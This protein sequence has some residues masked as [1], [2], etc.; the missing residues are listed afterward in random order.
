MLQLQPPELFLHL[1]NLSEVGFDVLILWIVYLV[2]EVDE[3][4][5]IALDD[6]ELHP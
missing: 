2:G 6:E 4:L 1:A 3:E 5:R